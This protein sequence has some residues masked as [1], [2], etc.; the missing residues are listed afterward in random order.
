[1]AFGPVSI[2]GSSYVL[3]PAT[4][5]F[6]GGVK[7]GDGILVSED[8]TIKSDLSEVKRLIKML[9]LKFT[10]NV[11]KNSFNTTFVNLDGLTV[12]GAWND[13]LARIEF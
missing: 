8:G 11:T 4:K 6:L 10:T 9:D 2:G 12:T 1:M 5:D 3:P 7:I 13:T